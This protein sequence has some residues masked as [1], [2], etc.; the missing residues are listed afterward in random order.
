LTAVQPP[1]ADRPTITQDLLAVVWRRRWVALATFVAV[2][3][4]VA[5][6]TASMP[7]TYAATAYMLVNPS[8]PAQSDF[9]QTQI[10]EALL[11]TYAELL[12][13]QSVADDAAQQ[14]GRS[15][16]SSLSNAIS[17]E[18]VADSQLLKITAEAD[19]PR[20]AQEITNAFTEVF[21]QRT[22]QLADSDASAG[23]ATVA[24]P[25]TLPTSAVRPRPALY[26]AAGVL[27]GLLA[28]AGMALLA[29]RLDQRLDFS[30]SMTEVLGLPILGRIPDGPASRL[31]AQL[32]GS[33]SQGRAA[34]ATAEAFRLLLANLAFANMGERPR[35]VAIVSS[36]EKEGKSTCAL[37]LSRTAAELSMATL[38]VEADLR[39]PSLTQKIDGTFGS[40]VGLSGVL[41]RQT[42]LGEAL[43]SPPE[44]GIDFLPAGALPPN[45]AALLGAGALRDFHAEA[46]E[47][48]G[49]VVYDT[50]PLS[51]A[52]DASYVAAI[53]DG[54]LLVIDERRT[55][56][57][58]AAHAVAQLRR[59]QANILGVVINRADLGAY[60]RDYYAADPTL[61]QS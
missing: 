18:A 13:T 29:Q 53:T 2:V 5:A 1:P 10:S 42:T 43:W 58:M 44:L 22:Q 37:N 16:G 27:L 46:R 50:P 20:E 21:E 25:A 39:R 19:T 14:L 61:V 33:S 55:R 15:D 8:R 45:P 38:L 35:S 9:E 54:V 26:L 51:V 3:G 31:A 36:D 56:R 7:K 17:V 23:R 24:E 30:E 60:A 6:L 34:H 40:R 49:M 28:A 57:K 4:A 48:Y 11:T 41:V 47:R 59:A 32:E 12:Q 52:A